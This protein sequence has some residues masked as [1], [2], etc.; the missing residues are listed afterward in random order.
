MESNLLRVKVLSI[1]P[2]IHYES[3]NGPAKEL[4]EVGLCQSTVG[5]LVGK[6]R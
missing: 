5:L 3:N 6:A 2:V 1:G 4:R